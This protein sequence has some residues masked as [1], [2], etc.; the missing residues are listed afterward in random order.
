MHRSVLL[1]LFLI[2]ALAPADDPVANRPVVVSRLVNSIEVRK[3]L[4]L[5]PD[6]GSMPA[7]IKNVKVAV[8]DAGFAGFDGKRPYLP[9]NAVLV[10]HYDRDFIKRF[11]LGDPEFT[12]PLNPADS[13]GRAMAQMVWAMTGN[14]QDGPQF[15]L[16]NANGPTMFRRAVRHAIEQKADIILFSSTFEGA[17]NY[18]GRGPINAAVD[19]AVR[20]G[21]LWINAAGNSGGQVFNGPVDVQ[22]D[23]WVRFRGTPFASSLRFTNRFDE[24][25]VTITLTWND[26]RDTEDAGTDKDLD[27]IVE[28]AKG[29]VVGSSTLKQIA[30]GKAADGETK[31]PRERLVLADLP[32][33]QTGQEYRIRVKA[34][35]ANFGPMD[36][37]RI[38]VSAQNM[39]PFTD[40]TTGKSAVPV[41]F[42]DASR[43]SG[44]YPPADHAVVL[45]VG[46]SA[47]ASS[48]GPT[49]DGRVK[50][51]VIIEDSLARFS[52]GEESAGSSNSAAYFAGAVVVLKAKEPKLTIG[53]L[54]AWVRKLDA[55]QTLRGTYSATPATPPTPS[56]MVPL[57]PNELRAMSTAQKL[58]E[59][60]VR[61]PGTIV[62]SGPNGTV[63][64]QP[65]T[66][67]PVARA[68]APADEPTRKPLTHA[69]WTAP[70]VSLLP[71]LLRER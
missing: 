8:L 4:G 30:A 35:T 45:T 61:P 27:L 2:P 55:V 23:G 10:E 28:D 31:N 6:Y 54:R 62:I 33:V 40:P 58:V 51:D 66:P 56:R 25:T 57:T 17:G 32:A 50:P 43:E 63:V 69:T 41:E 24:N 60:P 26:Y 19:D 70:P 44:L 48:T 22:A 13:H 68:Q 15:L 14:S 38:Q 49:A 39:A 34:K 71:D 21:I 18:D 3:K 20:A 29:R 53:H 52:N 12:K 47:N 67:T 46:D 7:G 1:L 36:R 42:L 64:I 11:N 9:A 16:L 59:D 65:R 37:L 5:L